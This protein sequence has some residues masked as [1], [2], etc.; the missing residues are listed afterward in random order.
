[1]S[2]DIILL[3]RIEKLGQMG[4][5]VSVKPGFARN[6]LLPQGKAVRASEDNVKRFEEQRA[7]LEAENLERRKEAERVGKDLEGL[8]VVII[9]AAS[10]TGQLYGSVNA[11]DIANAIKEAGV[12]VNRSQV[13]ME[14]PVKTL[15][16]F[17]FRIKLHPEVLVTVKI[18]VAQSQEEAEAQAERVS[19]GESAVITEAEQAAREMAEEAEQ[20]AQ[21][22]AQAAADMATGD[23][24]EALREA[25]AEAKEEAS[26]L[27]E[28]AEDVS[29]EGASEDE[30]E[31]DDADKA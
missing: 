14:R 8:S 24:A 15:G 4:D 30:S 29:D 17:D 5:V 21:A 20:Q 27:A 13:L 3:E 23:T 18:N 6:F 19:R 2:V 31:S 10:E 12:T 25:A 22:I 16:V 26:E 7:Q 9:R 28:V 11:R 1:M